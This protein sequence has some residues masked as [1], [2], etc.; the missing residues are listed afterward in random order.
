MLGGASCPGTHVPPFSLPVGIDLDATQTITV[1]ALGALDSG[2][3]GF[4]TGKRIRIHDRTTQAIVGPTA[5]F[6]PGATRTTVGSRRFVGST[7]VLLAAGFQRSIIASG[8]D[9]TDPNLDTGGAF[10]GTINTGGA[11]PSVGGS[12]YA[13][14]PT[15]CPTIVDGGPSVAT[16]P[17]ASSSTS[18]RRCPSRARGY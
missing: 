3:D 2:V 18:C 5:V 13:S 7:P 11:I 17:A 15:A 1:T 16:A 6:G 14:D 4:L 9:Q 8:F 12:C 10:P